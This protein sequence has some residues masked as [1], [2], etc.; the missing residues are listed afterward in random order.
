MVINCYRFTRKIKNDFQFTVYVIISFWKQKYASAINFISVPVFLYIVCVNGLGKRLCYCFRIESRFFKKKHNTALESLWNVKL[1]LPRSSCD[2][3]RYDDETFV[4]HRTSID[5]G[6]RGTFRRSVGTRSRDRALSEIK[7]LSG[8]PRFLLVSCAPPTLS[9]FRPPPPR[10]VFNIR[11]FFPSAYKLYI[12]FSR[13]CF[14]IVP[15]TT[16]RRVIYKR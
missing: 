11:F 13:L 8:N 9:F 7:N 10:T 14:P 6:D 2:I 5:R 12:V 16:A 4:D 1:Q 15:T 3:H